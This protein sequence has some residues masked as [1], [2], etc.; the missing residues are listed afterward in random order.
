MRYL[1]TPRTDDGD[2]SALTG[3]GEI[4]TAV[5]PTGYHVP[6]DL[7]SDK[8]HKTQ[9]FVWAGRRRKG[10]QHPLV[11][12]GT[13]VRALRVDG[14]LPEVKEWEQE[15]DWRT[16]AVLSRWEHRELMEET[17]SFIAL[18]DNLF[19]ADTV[20][21]NHGEQPHEITFTVTYRFGEPD[22]EVH[23]VR[24]DDGVAIAYRLE[25]HLGDLFFGAEVSAGD[26][27]VDR[28]EA[29]QGAVASFT[30]RLEPGQS[31]VLTTWL[32]FSDRLYYE[33]PVTPDKLN[34]AIERHEAAW[35]EFWS[36]S[37]VVT[38]HETVDDFRHSSL[39]ALRCQATPWSIPP[40]VSQPY[41]GA[42]SFHDEM[43]PFLGLLSSNY[44][45]LAERIPYFRLTTLPQAQAR[46]RARGA[47]YPWSSTEFGEERDPNGLWLTERFHLGQFAVCI[48]V[49]WLYERDRTQLD[50]LYPVLRDLARYFEMNMLEYGDG[51][52]YSPSVCGR[53]ADRLRTRPCV[54]FD[55]SV[56]TVTNGPFTICAAIVSME[57]AAH[58][59]ELLGKDTDRIPLWRTLASD[60]RLNLP[61]S[62]LENG[63]IENDLYKMP[64]DKPLHYAILGPVFPFRVDVN[65]PRARRSAEHIHTICRSMRGWKP[66]FSDVFTGSSWM[67]M[68]GHLGIVHALQGNAELAWDAVK[69]G[70]S[71]AGPF[72]SPNEHV[73][74]D[75]MIQVPWFTTG[76]GGWLYALNTLF[77]QVD[78]EGTKLLPAVPK[79]LKNARFRDL[80]A[81]GGVLVSG[82]FKRG[83]LA[84]LNARAARP[85]PWRFRLPEGYAQT[86]ALSGQ[87]V[88]SV[89]G[90][91]TVVMDEIGTAETSLLA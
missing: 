27:E 39:Y 43:Y 3:N 79:E 89:G 64:D 60:L 62:A 82:E 44:P 49:L 11:D 67:W 29:E 71:S 7:R 68:A 46:A 42:G 73:T 18:A 78:E 83:K 76:C 26:A 51:T 8:S 85:M 81:E 69:N 52:P 61:T 9:Y 31:V 16:G 24:K 91:Y 40:T 1:L 12:F 13:I 35:G 87:V 48:H 50:D 36:R 84:S 65:S 57:Y 45:D 90:W 22:A 66:G 74:G 77:V 88:T 56:G 37:E 28:R 30:A 41:W 23:P 5:S 15:I 25:D 54:D 38:G 21:K 70:P 32:H 53:G 58:A 75:D 20:L 14:G 80:R 59:A 2:V 33:F 10:P 55:E 72:L 17:R 47:L 6:P 4:C 86:S 63:K 34:D 19:C